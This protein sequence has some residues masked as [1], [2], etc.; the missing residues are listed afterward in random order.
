M[1]HIDITM[2]A[3]IRPAVL[4]STLKSFCTNLLTDRK[5]YRLI[6]NID[7]VGEKGRTK[8]DMLN[9]CNSFF[10]NVVYNYPDEPSFPKAA[11]WTWKQVKAPYFFHLEDDWLMNRPVEMK[12]LTK[13]L[14]KNPHLACVRLYKHNIPNKK[15]PRLFNSPYTFNE[16]ANYFQA[17]DSKKQFGLNPVLIRKEYIDEALPLLVEHKN[18]EKQF[19]YNNT[20]MRDFV[21]RWK[22]A[23]YGQPGDKALVSDNGYSWRNQMNFSKPTNGSQFLTWVTEDEND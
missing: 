12:T 15:N 6:I 8:E 4:E 5:I 2:T 20:K 22:Y 16:K 14:H 23:I 10:D 9:V 11:I 3:V 17:N 1:K 13:I 7:P 18:P 19:R 21:M